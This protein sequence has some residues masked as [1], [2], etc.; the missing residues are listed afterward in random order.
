VHQDLNDALT[1]RENSEKELT[2]RRLMMNR[3]PMQHQRPATTEKN[4]MYIAGLKQAQG[5][6]H[7][8]TLRTSLDSNSLKNHINPPKTAYNMDFRGMKSREL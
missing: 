7:V 4:R 3:P 1:I 5:Q 2:E 8:N 6:E